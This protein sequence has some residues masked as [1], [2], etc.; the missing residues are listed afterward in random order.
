MSSTTTL[1]PS[2]HFP[3]SMII[4]LRMRK[5]EE[6]VR[7]KIPNKEEAEKF[8]SKFKKKYDENQKS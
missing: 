2:Q 5:W 3:E 6:K 1:S 8:I 7:R 4:H